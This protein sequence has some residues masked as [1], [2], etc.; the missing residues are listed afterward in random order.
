MLIRRN[1]QSKK[2]AG[3]STRHIPFRRAGLRNPG[4]VRPRSKGR[5]GITKLQPRPRAF[6]S[7]WRPFD[8]ASYIAN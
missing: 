1:R 2:S 5:G 6:G 7:D 3:F 4:P 8:L